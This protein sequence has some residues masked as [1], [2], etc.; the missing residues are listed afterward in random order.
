MCEVPEE[1]EQRIETF[2]NLWCL[3]KTNGLFGFFS[4]RFVVGERD[5][6][7]VAVPRF[8]VSV[9]FAKSFR[10]AVRPQQKGTGREM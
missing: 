2:V 8:F 4:F 5:G 3:R 7:C 6:E 9:L 1:S 10:E